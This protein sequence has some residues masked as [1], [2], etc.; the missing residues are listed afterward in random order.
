[1]PIGKSVLPRLS[2]LSE[3]LKIN[4]LLD[5]P[6]QIKHLEES[7]KPWDAFIKIDVGARRAGLP[8][9]SAELKDLVKV[10]EASAAVNLKGFYCHANHSYACCTI[11]GAR[12]MLQDEIE[13]V[14][15]GASILP[16][17]RPLILSIGA[18]PTAHVIE[19]LK[20]DLPSNI[21]LE[22]HAGMMH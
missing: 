20:A 21:K 6:A 15:Q 2:K 3:C 14:L 12:S 16:S 4:L 17:T 7:A 9:S 1:M 19:S 10:V 8:G 18:T 13:G 11:E 22:L 5:H